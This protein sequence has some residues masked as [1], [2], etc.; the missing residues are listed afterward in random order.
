MAEERFVG[1][2]WL[3]NE[4]FP[5]NPARTRREGLRPFPPY[6]IHNGMKR[7]KHLFEQVCS[8]GKFHAAATAA[9]RGKR[10]KAPAAGRCGHRVSPKL[11]GRASRIRE[12]VSF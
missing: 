8:F 10:G 3:R 6:N 11:V 4:T 7:H 9:M 12:R 2:E 1:R 5:P